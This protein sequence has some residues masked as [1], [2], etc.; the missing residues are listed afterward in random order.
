MNKERRIYLLTD[1]EISYILTGLRLLS[2]KYIKEETKE[3]S[4][5]VDMLFNRIEESYEVGV[6]KNEKT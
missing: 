2:S 1:E 5:E 4:E 3:L 6:I